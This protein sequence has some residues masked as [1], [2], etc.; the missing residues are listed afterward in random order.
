[1]GMQNCTV[2]M[3]NSLKVSQKITNKTNILSSNSTSGYMYKG[4][5][6]SISKTY[7]YSHVHCRTI[8]NKQDVETI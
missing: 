8:H 1:M 3:E 5:E 7:Q 2:A 4:I 6:I